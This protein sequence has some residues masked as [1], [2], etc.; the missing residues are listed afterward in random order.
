MPQIQQSTFLALP[1]RPVD[2]ALGVNTYRH[3]GTIEHV[4]YRHATGTRNEFLASI[5]QHV[6]KSVDFVV[7][8]LTG[9]TNE[10]I[11]AVSRHIVSLSTDVQE[12]IIRI[13]F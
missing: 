8:D 9:F 13:G 10:Q 7:I 2:A 12:T 1:G 6:L 4:N 5:D 3:G 11:S